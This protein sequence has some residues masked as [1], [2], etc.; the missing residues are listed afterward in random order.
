MLGRTFKKKYFEME[1]GTEHKAYSDTDYGSNY[2]KIFENNSPEL[3][4]QTSP[5]DELDTQLDSKSSSKTDYR[6][7]I[8]EFFQDDGFFSGTSYHQ[9]NDTSSM[10]DFDMLLSSLA[11][12]PSGRDRF[13]LTSAAN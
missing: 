8:D 9:L 5:I 11:S 3:D 10:V 1:T 12:S 7:G 4:G 13:F 2:N 6:D